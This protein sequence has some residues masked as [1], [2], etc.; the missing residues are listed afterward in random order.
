MHGYNQL[1]Q[2]SQK[3][4]SN[5][6]R[7]HSSDQDL[8]NLQ[9]YKMLEVVFVPMSLYSSLHVANLLYNDNSLTSAYTLIQCGEDN[10]GFTAKPDGLLSINPFWFL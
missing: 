3:Y 8:C 1:G 6:P 9:C 2:H 4:N 5:Q 10:Y 7:T